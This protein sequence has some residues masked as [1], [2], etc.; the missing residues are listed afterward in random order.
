TASP[1][2]ASF[3]WCRCATTIRSWALSWSSAC[4]LHSE[5]RR[6]GPRALG[7]LR[8]LVQIAGQ[9]LEAGVD[10]DG[11]HDLA[12]PELLR[13]FEGAGQVESRRRPREE[14]FLASRAARHRPAFVLVDH[15]HLVVR[16]FDQ[17]R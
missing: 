13:D 14:A 11:R 1:G 12:G 2:P 8:L 10:G 7:V 17:V 16:A 9:V 4:S 3:P 6:Q 15:A 5:R